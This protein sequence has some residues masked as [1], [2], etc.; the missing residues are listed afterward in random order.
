LDFGFGVGGKAGRIGIAAVAAIAVET[1]VDCRIAAGCM[2]VAGSLAVVA[3]AVVGD[4]VDIAADSSALI[5]LLD[6]LWGD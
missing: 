2:A 6:C 5:D 1:V 3:V 4:T